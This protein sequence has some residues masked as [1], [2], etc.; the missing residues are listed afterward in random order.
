MYAPV[1]RSPGVPAARVPPSASAA[2]AARPGRR[3]RVVASARRR[4]AARREEDGE[5][6]HGDDGDDERARIGSR[7]GE[8]AVER[9]ADVD[10]LLHDPEL[11]VPCRPLPQHVLAQ[12]AVDARRRR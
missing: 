9:R 12:L 8:A 2:A 6:R 3:R 7:R 1:A 10:R 4:P 5:R 11:E